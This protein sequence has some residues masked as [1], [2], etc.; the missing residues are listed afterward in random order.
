MVKLLMLKVLKGGKLNGKGE[1]KKRG[2][3]SSSKGEKKDVKK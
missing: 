1:G 3:S 2:V